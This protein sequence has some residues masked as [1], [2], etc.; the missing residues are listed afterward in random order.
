[1]LFNESKLLTTCLLKFMFSLPFYGLINYLC[2][3][4]NR[5]VK[6]NQWYIYICS[7]T[8][9]HILIYAY[10]CSCD[11]KN[12]TANLYCLLFGA[13]INSDHF[14]YWNCWPAPEFVARI[15]WKPSVTVN[16]SPLNMFFFFLLDNLTSFILVLLYYWWENFCVIFQFLI[17]ETK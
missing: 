8:H 13:H 16:V 7:H 12:P 10:I 17:S 4:G 5:A 1:M 14:T 3:K 15:K 9:T 6:K 2:F 11:G